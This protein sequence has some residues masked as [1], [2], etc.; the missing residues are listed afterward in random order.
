MADRVYPRNYSPDQPTTKLTSENNNMAQNQGKPLPPPT[1]TYVVQIP[2]DQIYR[3]P[4]PENARRYEKLSR[5]NT[6]RNPCCCCFCWIL[7]VILILILL[8]VIAAVAFFFIYKPK[9][10]NYTVEDMSINGINLSG[11]FSSKSD[12]TVS[13]EFAVTVRAQNPNSRIGIYYEKGSAASVSHAGTVLCS[14]GLPNFYQPRNNV[15]VF[16]TMLKSPPVKLSKVAQDDLYIEQKKGQIPLGVDIK[17][18]ARVKAGSIRTWVFT[19]RV[20]CD[21]IV[22]KLAKDSK[23]VSKK[24]SVDPK[25]WKN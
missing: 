25:F 19:I 6:R 20:H 21:V 12:L 5:R 7:S 10:P 9:L 3:I 14:G 13:P 18:H 24:C 16:E 4:P 22:D 2:K 17:V 23:I 15:T 1:G 8:A 11:N